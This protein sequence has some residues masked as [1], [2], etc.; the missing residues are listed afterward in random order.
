MAEKNS[1]RPS[2]Q[3]KVSETQAQTETDIDE[4]YI[5]KSQAKRDV[6]ALQK[7]GGKLVKLSKSTLSK[8]DL[9]EG[10]LEQLLFT[11]TIRTNSAKRRQM[12][13]IGKLMRQVDADAIR[14]QY[15]RYQNQAVKANTYFHKLETWRDRLLIEGDAAINELLHE[16]PEF[17][18]SRL[19]QLLRNAKKESE[20]N[21]PPKST[22]QLFQYLKEVIPGHKQ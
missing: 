12:Q 2:Q 4:H 21:K 7:L 20:N 18:R 11:Q 1:Q 5:S 19:R 16:H 13:L 9:D 10:L 8:F 17:E 6:E 15:E 22:R 14:T 3:Q